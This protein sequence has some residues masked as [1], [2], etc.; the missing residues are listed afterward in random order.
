MKGRNSERNGT[1]WDGR[2]TTLGIR[3]ICSVQQTLF[4]IQHAMDFHLS[5]YGLVKKIPPI[6]KPN[7]TEN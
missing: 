4:I 6:L 2:V 5:F 7:D 1:G 3:L